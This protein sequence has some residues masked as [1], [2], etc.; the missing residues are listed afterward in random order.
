LRL[1]AAAAQPLDELDREA[2]DSLLRD[3][4]VE[5]AGELVR[6]PA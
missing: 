6:L 2:V 3:G 5:R 1:V 4:L